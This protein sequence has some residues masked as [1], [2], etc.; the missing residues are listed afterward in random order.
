M[1]IKVSETTP[2]QLDWLVAKC[3]GFGP[4]QYMKNIDIRLDVKGKASC[5]LVPIN[6]TYVQWSPTI[7]WAQGG[8]IIEREK[9]SV[10]PGSDAPWMAC[11]KD[12]LNRQAGPTPLIAAMRCYVSSKLGDEVEVP[13]ALR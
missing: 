7:D 6:R 5:L 2:L 12:A 10:C 8:P 13:D 1:K 4:D 9:L 3:E 11:D